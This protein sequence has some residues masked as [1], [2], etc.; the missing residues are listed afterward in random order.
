MPEFVDYKMLLAQAVRGDRQA[1]LKLVHPFGVQLRKRIGQRLPVRTV[2]DVDDV[3]QEVYIQVFRDIGACQ[4][5]SP[6]TLA[7]IY[8]AVDEFPTDQRE[9]IRLH[10]L[11]AVPSWKRQS[12]S[13][14]ARLRSGAWC[15]GPI[16]GCGT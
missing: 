2:M 15:I 6:K 13:G 12:R 5:S 9:V 3:L 10:V 4:A 8:D 1:T 7:T 14:G 16:S 11:G